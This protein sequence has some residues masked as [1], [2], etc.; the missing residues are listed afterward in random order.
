MD[1]V[2]IIRGKS[3]TIRGHNSDILLHIPDG[4]YAA[5]IGNIHTHPT[6]FRHHIPGKDC[7]VAPICEYHLQPFVGRILPRQLNCEL[8]VPHVVRNVN[9]VK[10][11]IRVRHGDLHGNAVLPVYHLLCRRTNLK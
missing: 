5:L 4:V 1:I 6:K 7:L 8:K 3:C 11:H 2:K 9:E 10:K